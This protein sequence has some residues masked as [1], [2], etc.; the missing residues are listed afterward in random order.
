MSHSLA[1]KPRIIY[2]GSGWPTN[3]GNAF[4]GLGATALL[5]AAAPEAEVINL[6]GTPRWFFGSQYANN[7]LDVA[8]IARC[9]LAVFGGMSMCTEFVRIAGPTILK[10][11]KRG[12]DVLLMGS[13]GCDYTPEEQ[14]TYTEF[15]RQVEPV[16]FIS[17]D[18][19]SFLAYSGVA[20][21]SF[22]GIDCGFFAPLAYPAPPVDFPPYVVMNFDSQDIPDI[23]PGSHAVIYTHHDCWGPIPEKRKKRPNTLVSD[24]P[25]D[26]LTIYAGAERVYSD[27]VHACVAALSYGRTAQLFNPTPR[28]D[29]FVAAGAHNVRERPVTL[30]TSELNAKRQAQIDITTRIIRECLKRR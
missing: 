8:S 1:S 28:S 18:Q 21:Q 16:A 17:R 12:V 11:R 29:L 14:N 3:I 25:Y 6:G 9:D 15:L 4:I 19:R 30:D 20:E 24:L 5:R 10:L 13:G 2:Y 7:A 26:Y 27:R 23:D 22:A